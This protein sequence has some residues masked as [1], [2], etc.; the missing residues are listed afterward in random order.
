[1]RVRL[2]S[3]GCRLNIGEIEAMARNLARQGHRVVG[4][5]EPA[6]L[7]ILNTCT[8]TSIASKKS[9]QLIRQMRRTNP[10]APIIAT[11]CDVEIEPQL[12]RD[13]G[14]DLI[15]PNRD[16]DRL[17]DLAEAA[18]LLRDPAPDHDAPIFYG[19]GNGLRTR[20]FLKIQDGC[21]H[22]CAFCVTTIARGQGRSLA[23]NELVDRV[24]ALLDDGYRE[25]VLT[26]V[27]LGSYGHDLGQR[28]GLRTLVKRMLEETP[29]PRLRLSSLE[30]W[31]LDSEFFDLF[32]S[33][34]LQPH[35]H[36][37]L[38][39]GCDAT[40]RRMARRITTSEFAC[41]VATA[42]S[43]VPNLAVST[44]VIVGFPG[45]TDGEFEES[46]AFIDEMAFSRLHVF[47]YSRREGTPA[48][49]MP[50]QIPGSVAHQRSRR[51]HQ[52]G[53]ELEASF[54]HRLVGGTFDVLWETAEDLD[55][56]LR[57]SGLTPNYVRVSTVTPANAELHNRISP[58][59]VLEVVPGGVVGRIL[60]SE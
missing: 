53:A 2:E 10:A 26:G 16:K 9:R 18:G 48:A 22:R 38:Q 40:L 35:V 28:Q 51:V 41:L 6:E 54:N 3:V 52:L 37:P 21:D 20:A 44:D 29:V 24:R 30:P 8:V 55:A 60:S 4:P 36:L 49:V 15:V 45:E 59:R 43:A 42:R 58:T 19:P 34:R 12:A 13:A 47:R 57:W 46:L 11:G 27:H 5:G 23:A 31:D 56:C 14:V 1:M 25:V 17:L 7:S 33:S 50:D 32:S 39:S